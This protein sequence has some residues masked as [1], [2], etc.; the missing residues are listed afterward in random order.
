MKGVFYA[1]GVGP[2]DPDLLTLKAIKTIDACDMIV[3]PDSGG[4]ENIALKIAS[5]YV[6]DKKI[7][8]V[9]MPMIK[10]EATLKQYHEQAAE[11]IC[12]QLDDGKSVAFLTLG[13]PTIYSTVMYVH[14][15]IQQKGYATEVV[16]GIPSFC[17]AAAALGQSLC[18]RDE[19]LHIIP[20]TFGD[21]DQVIDLPGV[22]VLMKS[23]KTLAAVKDK[24]QHRSVMAVEYAT[25]EKQKIYENVEALD[26]NMSYFS[27]IIV[28]D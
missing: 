28:R 3:A 17:A 5:A 21:M 9:K 7:V 4:K 27:V 10:N 22:K 1:V 13:D 6:K 16:P 14:T 8:E 24:L 2:G 18:L 15:R 25:M 11:D 20:A 12:R 26:E 19:M 23:G